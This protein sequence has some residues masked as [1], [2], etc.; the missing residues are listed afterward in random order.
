MYIFYVNIDGYVNKTLYQNLN[1]N[2]TTTNT[3]LLNGVMLIHPIVLYFFYGLYVLEYKVNFKKINTQTKKI[4]SKK[5]NQKIFSNIF[6][7]IF[8]IILGG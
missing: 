3:N 7:I 1:N 8:A 4:K 6:I 2:L 5:L